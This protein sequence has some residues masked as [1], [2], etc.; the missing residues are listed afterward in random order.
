[1]EAL[2]LFAKYA[3]NKTFFAIILSAI[4][5]LFYAF[6]IPVVMASLNMNDGSAMQERLTTVLDFEVVN[7][8]FATLFLVLCILIMVFRSLSGVLLS[9]LALEIRYRLRKSLY[10]LV[11]HSSI[12][13]LERV[14]EPRLIQALSTDVAT[15]VM[16]AQMFPQLLTNAVTIIGML[17]YLAYLDFDTFV[18]VLEVIVF[19]TISYQLPVYFGT[20]YFKESRE[21]KDILQRA[22]NGLVSGA[23]E[24]KLSVD[25]QEKF[26]TDIL[27]KE[28]QEMM[29]LE[30]KGM[31]IYTLAGNYGGLLCFFA[32]GGLSFIF[33]NYHNV[34]NIQMMAAV[35]VLLY[36]TGP[37]NTL[38]NFVP[39]FA[40]TKISLNKINRLNFELRDESINGKAEKVAS[41]QTLRFN[42]V[43]YRHPPVPFF[44]DSKGFAVGPVSFDIN[45]GEVTF[46]TGGNGSGKSTLAKVISLHYR[47][48][49]GTICFD[50]QV[51]TDDNL[52]S[53]RNEISCIYSDYHLFDRPLGLINCADTFKKHIDHYLKAF[54]LDNKVSLTDGKFSTLKLSDGQRRRLALITAIVEDKSLY[55]FDEWAADQDPE[56]KHIF[57][58]EILPDLKRKG[59]AVVVISHDDRYFHMADKLLVME[60]G[61]LVQS[62]AIAPL[63]SGDTNALTAGQ[64]TITPKGEPV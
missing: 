61:K 57:Y 9:H 1:M 11:R 55:L 37:I 8:P 3:P 2:K 4:S 22:F 41:W 36:V 44:E 63:Q 20:R 6:L 23:K 38:L 46:I 17:G 42:D 32:I 13:Q 12:A 53:Y 19:G 40:M 52:N 31:T 7:A 25:K 30:R 5:G 50:Q 56:F 29:S 21:R 15:I 45:C 27:C 48:G 34:S 51:V 18:F 35:M 10:R 16:G 39:Q 54:E 26:E 33:I 64:Q 14:G 62:A 47:P 43:S 49:Q 60:S 28:E 58:N 24:L 59:K